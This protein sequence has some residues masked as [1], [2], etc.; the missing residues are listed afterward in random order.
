MTASH[1]TNTVNS[2]IDTHINIAYEIALKEVERLA[3]KILKRNKKSMTGFC[4][5]MGCT[6][7]YDEN[8]PIDDNDPRIKE[9]EDFVGTW[10]RN[11]Y[12]TGTPMKLTSWD[13]ELLSDW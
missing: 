1:Q 13:G 12:L 3:R 7:F 6:S 10:N 4:M 5:G 11:L 2:K 8:G 9:L